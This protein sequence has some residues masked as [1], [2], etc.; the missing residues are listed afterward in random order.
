MTT[1]KKFFC[2]LLFE[3]TF[4]SDVKNWKILKK[5]Q[6]S[7]NQGFSYFFCL[8]MEG[9]GSRSLSVQIMTD[10]DGPTTYGP[11]STTLF[12]R[13]SQIMCGY[14]RHQMCYVTKRAGLALARVRR[15]WKGYILV[16]FILPS[17]GC[18]CFLQI[19]VRLWNSQS[20]P[21]APKY[22]LLTHISP[23]QLQ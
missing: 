20:T 3:G 11:G 1:K 19:Y 4:T 18:G 8:M 17:L 14:I 13:K 5:S 22:I 9:S 16:I 10:S 6:N 7:R 23:F 21:V 15:E 2:L 12:S